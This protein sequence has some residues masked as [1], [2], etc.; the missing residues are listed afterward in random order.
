[1]IADPREVLR[2]WLPHVL[3]LGAIVATIWLVAYVVAP[4]FEPI[5][6]AAAMAMLTAPVLNEPVYN[7]LRRRT[8]PNWSSSERL[9]RWMRFETPRTLSDGMSRQIAGITATVLVAIVLLTPVIVVLLTSARNLGEVADL[10]VGI[11]TRNEVQLTRLVELIKGQVEE[12]HTIYPRLE[13]SADGIAT[14]IREM[15][16]EATDVTSAST[17]FSVVVRGLSGAAQMAL[18][19]ISLAFFFV[20]GPTLARTLLHYSPLRE[21]QQAALLTHHR[22]TVLRLLSDTVASAVVKG[23]VLGG[24]VWGI[25][26]VFWNGIFPFLPIAAVAGVITLLPLVGVTIVWLP[27]ATLMAP[28]QPVGAAVLGISCWTANFAI[29][30]VR[31][32]IGRRIDDRSSW[33]SFLL[34]LGLVGG[35]LS[36]GLKGLLIGPMAVVL[37]ST[38]CS[39]W[40]PLYGGSSGDPTT[41][42][43]AEPENRVAEAG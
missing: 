43:P 33:R 26:Q 28:T 36:F 12:I 16:G 11:V 25:D 7:W 14:W 8:L 29:E 20:Q 1:M 30:R 6:L 38:V 22:K 2:R 17:W 32:W 4:L 42:D 23:L 35:L 19:I 41:A 24:I 18:A 27:I 31:A 13:L 37:V 3:M 40:L 21:A 39:A 5:L 9:P 10:L 34:F 15:L